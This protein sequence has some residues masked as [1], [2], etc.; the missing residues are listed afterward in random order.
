[1]HGEDEILSKERTLA[2]YDGDDQIVTSHELRVIL[3]DRRITGFKTG[4]TS[5]D[6]SISSIDTG[7]LTVISGPTGNGKTLLAQTLTRNFTKQDIGCLWFTYEVPAFFFL[8]QFGE[9]LPLFYMPKILKGNTM[10]WLS[11]RIYE[12]V[13]K[14]DISVVFI[15]HLHYLIDLSGKYN[16]SLEIGFLMRSLKKLALH[17]KISI[18][19]IA[20]QQKIKDEKEPDNESLRD[21]SFVAQE[22]DNVFFI[23]RKKTN[24]NET[25]LKIT[26]NRKKGILNKKVNLIK[27]ENYL[28]EVAIV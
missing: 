8:K 22:A 1:M 20:H 11:D 4:I 12:A 21:S 25:I 2:E 24:P 27:V 19:I 15:D 13:L 16:M 28:E 18:F 7:E 26:K 3:K 23:W 17:H 5:L 6:N 9:D 10:K 14:R